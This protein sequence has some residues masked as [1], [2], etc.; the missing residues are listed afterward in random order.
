MKEVSNTAV[1]RTRDG[2]GRDGDGS[3]Q[4]AVGGPRAARY[5]RV[6]GARVCAVYSVS[7]RDGAEVPPPA[8]EA[9]H[10]DSGFPSPTPVG[11]GIDGG[12]P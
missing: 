2:A 9:V 11:R 8:V 1:S 10:E 3:H 5:R 7:F 12:R 6:R 4:A